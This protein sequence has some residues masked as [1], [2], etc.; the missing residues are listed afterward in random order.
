[1]YN[2][3]RQIIILFLF[4]SNFL[5]AQNNSNSDTRKFI[6]NA[7]ITRID[8]DW[9]I[10]ANLASGLGETVSFFP[11]EITDLKTGQKVK[12]LQVDMTVNCRGFTYF[13]SSWVDLNEIS[14]FI[15]FV[16]TYIIP[17]LSKKAEK[18]KSI[19]YIFKSKEIIISFIIGDFNNTISVYLKDEG[20][21]D[22]QCY[23]W[24][25]TQISKSPELLSVLQSLK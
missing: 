14:E 9:N 10:V 19:T 1:M 18:R 24:T 20:V 12:A 15:I 6:E 4:A 25:K 23:F 17:N 8:R 5:S 2:M 22:E 11:V 7:D 16:E 3:R 21:V 13:K